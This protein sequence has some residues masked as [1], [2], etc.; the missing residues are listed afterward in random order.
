MSELTV[1]TSRGHFETH[2]DS[3]AIAK[4]HHNPGE[5]LWLDLVAPGPDDFAQLR[6][7]FG[8]HPLALEDASRTHHRPKVDSYENYY[9]VVFYCI[10]LDDEQHI[11]LTTLYM[12]IAQNYLVT[13]HAE[14]IPQIKET[15]R[16]W[17][18]PSSPL[19]QDVGSLIYALLD[20]IVD[21]YFP[22][23]D[24]VAD[25]VEAL[26]ETI[27]G[28]FDPG[29][30][31]NIFALKKEL[32]SMRR[33]VA[34]ERDVVNIMLR[35]DIKVFDENDVTYLQ[36]VYDHVV[37][38]IDA[39]DIYRDLLSSALDSYLSVQSN[40]LNQI[41]KI[42][43]LT[44]IIL[45][46]VTAVAGI[47]GMNFDYMPELHWRYGYLWALGLMVTIALALIYWF[48]RIRWL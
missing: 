36:D 13:V 31:Q 40:S 42:L 18:N 7:K 6:E 32:L 2:I 3:E 27:F 8:F 19:G 37:R 21:D 23:I 38:I 15:L 30:L 14:P 47:Y 22:V 10:G 48:R 34:P 11:T 12:F 17:R 1:C 29:S 33:A 44:S 9:F 41:V 46:S 25:R 4:I 45:M 43:T 24:S 16:R 39:V 5:T 35:R 20:A 28:N 26:E